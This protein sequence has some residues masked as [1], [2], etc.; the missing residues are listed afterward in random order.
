MLETIKKYD[1]LIIK[2]PILFYVIGFFINTIYL[3]KYGLFEMEFLKTRYIYIGFMACFYYFSLI[4]WLT[5]KLNTENF[6]ENF[7]PINFS[8]WILRIVLGSYIIYK[9]FIFKDCTLNIPLFIENEVISLK[10]QQIYYIISFSLFTLILFGIFVNFKSDK[11]L[12]FQKFLSVICVPYLI[13]FIY[14]FYNNV[15]LRNSFY[16]VLNPALIIL[17]FISS[18]S[19]AERGIIFGGL[20]A[21]ENGLFQKGYFKIYQI[22]YLI[23]ISIFFLTIYSNNIYPNI[24][25]NLGGSKCEPSIIVTNNEIFHGNILNENSRWLTIILSKDNCTVSIPDT[26]TNESTEAESDSSS[27]QVLKRKEFDDS[28]VVLRI[29]ND[30]VVSITN[31]IR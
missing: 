9:F 22:Y 2:I 28:T 10:I 7:K 23:F 3:N 20:L 31:I 24:N 29:K 21:T 4:I 12:P 25:K 8:Y 19:D 6:T 13:I 26:L 30:D 14:L 17:M 18:A 16:F 15:E 11:T 5:L 1:S 27:S